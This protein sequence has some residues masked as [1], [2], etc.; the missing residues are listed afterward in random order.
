MVNEDVALATS[1]HVYRPQITSMTYYER[2][3]SELRP[4]RVERVDDVPEVTLG[5][6][7]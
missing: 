6:A 7:A 4:V 1:V 5:R 2:W 3:G